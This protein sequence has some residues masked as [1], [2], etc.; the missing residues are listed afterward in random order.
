MLCNGASGC[1]NT[2]GKSEPCVTNVTQSVLKNNVIQA[3][4]R[5]ILCICEA[6]TW[7]DATDILRIVLL[8][9]PISGIQIQKSFCNI[10]TKP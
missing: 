5:N 6:Q 4:S 1:K 9:M 2:Q 8:K 10:W 7:E 3:G